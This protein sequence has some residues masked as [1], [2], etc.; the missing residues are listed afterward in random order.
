MLLKVNTKNVIERTQ[1]FSGK[2]IKNTSFDRI[3]KNSEITD[4]VDKEDT[5]FD[6]KYDQMVKKVEAINEKLKKQEESVALISQYAMVGVYLTCNTN[7]VEN[8]VEKA[9]EFQ[10]LSYL[11]FDLKSKY[12]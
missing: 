8:R 1:G 10:A 3:F 7:S 9:E 5:R 11:Y 6:G 4:E 2:T 12:K